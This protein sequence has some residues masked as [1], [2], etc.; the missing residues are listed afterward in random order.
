VI[1]V[2]EADDADLAWAA[3][4][5]QG[6]HGVERDDLGDRSVA[7]LAD[8]AAADEALQRGARPRIS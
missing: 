8:V 3:D 5:R 6:G 4:R 2:V 1:G 7:G